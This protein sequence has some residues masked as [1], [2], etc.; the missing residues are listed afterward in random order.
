MST[1][2]EKLLESPELPQTP[3]QPAFQQA[4]WVG[5]TPGAGECIVTVIL[6]KFSR[7]TGNTTF[8][9]RLKISRG[10]TDPNAAMAELQKHGAKFEWDEKTGHLN[11]LNRKG[12]LM[13]Y[14]AICK[15]P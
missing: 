6:G 12:D 15:V 3:T 4:K 14:A 8:G 9:G 10:Y 2:A 13:A 11:A 7:I 1:L 5:P